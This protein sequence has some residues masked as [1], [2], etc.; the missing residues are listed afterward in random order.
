MDEADSIRALGMLGDTRT[1]ALVDTR[2]C[3]VWLCLPHF[4]G[5]PVFGQLLAGS[6]GGSFRL[7]PVGD[8]TL[9]G[10]RYRPQSTVLE[11]TWRVGPARLVLTEGMVADVAGDLFPTFCL[12]RRLE[13]HGA[14]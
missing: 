11:T 2:G 13:A 1:A 5:E 6:D 3:V 14:P 12:V 8:A 10:R 7:G 4:D 9:V